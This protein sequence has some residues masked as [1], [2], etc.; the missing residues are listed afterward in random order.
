MLIIKL[1]FQVLWHHTTT[2]KTRNNVKSKYSYSQ[3]FLPIDPVMQPFRS[4][5]ILEL[6]DAHSLIQ[7]MEE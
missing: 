5:E 6:D 1:F 2:L 7:K 4:A 3:L